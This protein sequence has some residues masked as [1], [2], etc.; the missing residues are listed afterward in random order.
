MKEIIDD[1]FVFSKPAKIWTIWFGFCVWFRSRFSS[2][3]S[4][5]ELSCLVSVKH[6]RQTI[7]QRKT[8]SHRYPDHFTWKSYERS[9]KSLISGAGFGIFWVC[10]INK[11]NLRMFYT[12]K[13]S[14]IC[15]PRTLLGVARKATH[16]RLINIKTFWV[17]P[18][19]WIFSW[20]NT[21]SAKSLI[22]IKKQHAKILAEQWKWTSTL[23]AEDNYQ[24]SFWLSLFHKKKITLVCTCS[25]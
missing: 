22:S 13:D 5:T 11:S 25:S 8:H 18:T 9:T 23:S 16:E 21:N 4:H 10:I 12:L 20:C 19:N 1:E 6:D 17:T 24:V 7:F 2:F 3:D 15:I 14:Q